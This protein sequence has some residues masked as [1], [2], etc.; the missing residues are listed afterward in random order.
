V[1]FFVFSG[2]LTLSAYISTVWSVVFHNSSFLK[3]SVMS[4]IIYVLTVLFV[5]YVIYVVLGDEISAFIKNNFR[6]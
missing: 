3:V 6:H 5:A 2:F 4:A 1:P